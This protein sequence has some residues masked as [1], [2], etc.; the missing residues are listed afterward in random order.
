MNLFGIPEAQYYCA[1]FASAPGPAAGSLRDYVATQLRGVNSLAEGSPGFN[2]YRDCALRDAERSLFLAVSHYRRST[3][4]MLASASPWAH[5]TLYYCSYFAANSLL[6]LFGGW[7]NN[8]TVIDV[9]TNARGNQQL[10]ITRSVKT[11]NN[12]PHRIFWELFY[13]AVMPLFPWVPSG[14][15]LAIQPVAGNV[16]WQIDNRNA[17]N[18]DTYA[19]YQLSGQF[20][21]GFRRS[22]FR[23]TLP[24]ALST[25][26][27]VAEAML[28]TAC[29]FGRQFGLETDALAGLI[30][31]GS[32]RK[33]IRA[34]I[35]REEIPAL[36]R[37]LRRRPVFV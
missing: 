17:L 3:D 24:G 13:N 28:L 32:R 21:V 19:A 6:G 4:L 29:E 34:L 25:Q 37:N 23:T 10:R 35:F 20:Q 26:F 30:P 9:A 14:L 12:G 7:I 16:T 11:V 8:R 33:K 27:R 31:A 18:Y 1:A 36:A 5:V 2:A 15:L 22:R